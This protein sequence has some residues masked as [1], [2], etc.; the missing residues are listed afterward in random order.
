MSGFLMLLGAAVFVVILL[1][2]AWYVGTHLEFK[3]ENPTN[4]ENETT[5]DKE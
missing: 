1:F 2:G 5:K 3:K 4:N